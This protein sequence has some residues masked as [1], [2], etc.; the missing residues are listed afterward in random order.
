MRIQLL[1]EAL[2]ELQSAD[3]FSSLLVWPT[4]S[5]CIESY[6]NVD[7]YVPR[8]TL[9]NFADGTQDRVRETDSTPAPAANDEEAPSPNDDNLPRSHHHGNTL[10]MRIIGPV[11]TLVDR[12]WKVSVVSPLS[13]RTFRPRNLDVPG[14][15]AVRFR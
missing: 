12:P 10:L 4:P 3:H 5:F 14:G 7:G 11:I 2:Q 8:H 15:T 13:K 9:S 6:N 1:T